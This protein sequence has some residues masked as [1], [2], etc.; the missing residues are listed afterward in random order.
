MVITAVVPY[1]NRVGVEI[2]PKE[3]ANESRLT[4]K[5][6]RLAI[7]R[8]RFERR[9]RPQK[10]RGFEYIIFL[11]RRLSRDDSPPRLRHLGGLKCINELTALAGFESQESKCYNR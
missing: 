10:K 6:L 8:H 9:V 7:D 2:R 3:V 1:S 4:F 5:T 11:L